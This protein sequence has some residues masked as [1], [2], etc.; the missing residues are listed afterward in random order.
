MILNSYSQS[1]LDQC[2]LREKF[3]SDV[4]AIV[5]IQCRSIQNGVYSINL[6]M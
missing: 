2:D 4:R 6:A 1:W 5:I 3:I